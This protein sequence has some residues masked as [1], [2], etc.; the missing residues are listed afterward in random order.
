[1]VI[2]TNQAF[3]KNTPTKENET[4]PVNIVETIKEDIIEGAPNSEQEPIKRRSLDLHDL[5]E[6]PWESTDDKPKRLI[7]KKNGT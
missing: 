1:L 4:P 3:K 6:K 2:A 5:G 7:Y